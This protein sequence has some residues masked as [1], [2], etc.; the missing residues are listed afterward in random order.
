[1]RKVLDELRL[2]RDFNQ[3]YFFP[4]LTMSS[5]KNLFKERNLHL[6]FEGSLVVKGIFALLE[7]IGGVLAYFITQ[8][9]LLNLV[10]AVTREELTEDPRDFIANHIVR[11][12][13][14]FS[15]GSQQFI[16]FYLLSHGIIKLF[17]IVGLLR[18]KLWC[19]PVSI[20]VFILFIAYQ[21]FRFTITHSLWLLIITA[22]D[23]AVIALTWHEYR[24]LKRI[25]Y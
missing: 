4:L 5:T 13:Q 9:F 1:M 14:Q 19:Y 12:A 11:S 22:F 20:I 21:L 18:K 24:H 17:L 8:Q 25:V 6:M 10:L 16:S 15:I 2:K 7:I 3:A 23:I